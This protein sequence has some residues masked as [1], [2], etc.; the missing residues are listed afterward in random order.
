MAIFQVPVNNATKLYQF[1]T[2]LD[3]TK[4]SLRIRYNS[5]NDCWYMTLI[6][7]DNVTILESIPLLSRVIEMIQPY[8]ILPDIMYG[9]FIV[10]DTQ[11]GTKDCTLDN[12]GDI[13]QLF[14][15]NAD[16]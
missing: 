10:Q 12:F 14:Y 15:V 2:S 11:D 16:L 3:R 7:Q 8:G 9:D 5:R 4:L 6:D 1:V 13:V